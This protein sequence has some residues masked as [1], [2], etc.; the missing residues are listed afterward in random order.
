MLVIRDKI[1]T[2]KNIIEEDN[3][4]K[5]DNELDTIKIKI[6]NINREIDSKISN[7]NKKKGIISNLNKIIFFLTIILIFVIIYYGVKKGVISKNTQN[8][9][10]KLLKNQTT[11]G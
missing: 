11:I 10:N 1:D 9:I 8:K 6:E 3:Y 4:Y 2:V 7:N 5:E